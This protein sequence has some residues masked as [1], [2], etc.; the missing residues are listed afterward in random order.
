[1]GNHGVVLGDALLVLSEVVV[2][3]VVRL[4]VAVLGA[5]N[6]CALARHL[7]HAYFLATVPAFIQVLLYN[8]KSVRNC[9]N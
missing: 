9:R 1:M 2:G 5:E 7:H 3:A 6:E 8:E 4:G